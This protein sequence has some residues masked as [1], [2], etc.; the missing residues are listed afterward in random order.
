M[1][2]QKTKL[3]TYE[4]IQALVQ[5]DAR[6]VAI[7]VY[8]E[9]ATQYGVPKVPYHVHNGVDSSLV[10]EVNLVIGNK[11]STVFQSETSGIFTLRNVPNIRRIVMHGLSSDG[12][13]VN[14]CTGEAIFGRCY[15]FEG[16]DAD[17]VITTN[18]PGVPF[19][20]GCTFLTI[21]GGG[22]AFTPGISNIY[23]F[24]T[25]DGNALLELIDYNNGTLTFELTLDPDWS[26]SIDIMI[27]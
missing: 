23:T 7:K 26:V 2:K 10:N 9:K 5:K 3:E 27:S 15:G 16:S 12:D 11:L 17:V 19:I 22:A 25:A 21:R 6:D 13:D 1:A 20:Q 4:E 18:T 24:A 14:T 8:N